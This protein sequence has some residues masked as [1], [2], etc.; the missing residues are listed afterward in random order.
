MLSKYA[1]Q[2][3]SS[4]SV[5]LPGVVESMSTHIV[6]SLLLFFSTSP[7][8]V[9]DANPQT[10][11]TEQFGTWGY[12]VCTC[13]CVYAWM[14]MC[15]CVLTHFHTGRESER[16]RAVKVLPPSFLCSTSA[17][18]PSLPRH[19]RDAAVTMATLQ[20]WADQT[21]YSRAVFFFFLYFLSSYTFFCSLLFVSSRL[22]HGCA[23]RC[24]LYNYKDPYLLI[25]LA[26]LHWDFA[27][28]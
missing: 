14:C 25:Y 5:L 2:P 8:Q 16:G 11:E 15:V 22:C 24:C 7:H 27:Q 28:Q 23:S 1:G 20:Q 18:S 3:W 13:V 12:S 6:L 9:L 10:S 21:P 26:C 17:D 19:P 4:V